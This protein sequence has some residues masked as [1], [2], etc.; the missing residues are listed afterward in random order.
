M[1]VS[2]LFI[3]LAVLVALLLVGGMLGAV[4]SVE[5]LI[6]LVLVVAWVVTW[7]VSRRKRR[8]TP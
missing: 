4:G 1:S 8:T 2:D 3:G 6:W 7:V 5:T